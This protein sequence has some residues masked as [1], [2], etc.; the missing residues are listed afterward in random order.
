[1]MSLPVWQ[2]GPMFLLG[3]LCLWSHVSSERCLCPV[4]SLSSRVSVQ[5]GLCPEGSLT[6][7]P[8]LDRDPVYSDESGGM[9]P[10]GMLSCL[11]VYSLFHK[12]IKL[13]VLT[14]KD[15][16][17]NDTLEVIDLIPRGQYFCFLKNFLIIFGHSEA[18][19]MPIL[20]TLSIMKIMYLY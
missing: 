18:P 8:P 2:T 20:P 19:L 11:K 7:R 17:R 6:G 5:G 1:M 3:G 13:S 12:S 10:T 14:F 16:E 15:S 9:H 4:G